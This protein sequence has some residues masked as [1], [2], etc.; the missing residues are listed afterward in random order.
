VGERCKLCPKTAWYWVP[1]VRE[2]V[3][4]CGD[5]KAEAQRAMATEAA[6][7]DRS[8]VDSFTSALSSRRRSAA[9]SRA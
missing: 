1:K 7:G 4:Y 9:L 2:T 8:R 3:Y 5:H 6:K